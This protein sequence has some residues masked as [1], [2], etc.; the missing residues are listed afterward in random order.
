MSVFVIDVTDAVDQEDSIGIR[1]YAEYVL[2]SWPALDNCLVLRK[3]AGRLNEFGSIRNLV[4]LKGTEG[5][6]QYQIQ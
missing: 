3:R 6:W 2:G 4:E 5:K 1:G